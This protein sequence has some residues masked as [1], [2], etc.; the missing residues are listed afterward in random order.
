[1]NNTLINYQEVKDNQ[2]LYEMFGDIKYK[3]KYESLQGEIL[4]MIYDVIHV[5][6]KYLM[7]TNIPEQNRTTYYNTVIKVENDARKTFDK[8]MGLLEEL[9][10]IE[11]IEFF[12]DRIDIK[13]K[14]SYYLS[15]YDF[16]RG[17]I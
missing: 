4:L 12:G 1:M 6:G 8:I 5:T 16:T 14:D 15:L 7:L 17:V 11:T 10:T 3:K 2:I 13:I 9:G